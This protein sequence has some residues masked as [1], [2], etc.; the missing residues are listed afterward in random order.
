MRQVIT[1]GI[2]GGIL[3]FSWGSLSHLAIGLGSTGVQ[4]IPNQQPVLSAMKAG[5]SQ[6]GFYLFPGMHVA[7]GA[8]A[9]QRAD[10]VKQ[11]EQQYEKGPYGILI[12]HPNGTNPMSPGKLGI[13]F[14]LNL[15][16]ALIASFLVWRAKING[17]HSC[18]GF[19]VLLGI[20]AAIATNVEYWNWYGF[21]G[22]Y[23]AS[24]MLDKVV[25]F[26]VVGIAIAAVMKR[27]EEKVVPA[28]QAA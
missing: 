15:V 18:V 5:I 17:F 13:E 11:F 25:G 20:L 14:G 27:P 21:P 24:Y 3:L 12:Y 26:L 4:E 2:L 1:A 8:T 7:P 23:T 16:E 10:A 9:Q 22:N 6:S 28:N 19:V